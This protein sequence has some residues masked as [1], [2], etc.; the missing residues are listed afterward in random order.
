MEML[1]REP[2]ERTVRQWLAFA[3]ALVSALSA[4]VAA[5]DP[6]EER[7]LT[8]RTSRVAIVPFTNI[9]GVA[10]DGWIGVGI[11]ETLGAELQPEA[12]EVIA[13]EFL[14]S[15]MRD[16]D[17]ADNVSPDD[18]G[19]LAL[20]RRVG[21]QWVVSGGYQRVADQIRI[22]ARLVEVR[23]GVVWCGRRESMARS[24][25]SSSCRTRSPTRS[26]GAQATVRAIKLTRGIRLDAQL[27]EEVYHSVPPITDLLQ[28]VP[29]EGSIATEKTEAWIMFDQNNLYFAARVWDSAPPS[30]WVANE[31]LA[32]PG[33]SFR[34]TRSA[35]RSIRSTIGATGS[36]SIPTPSAA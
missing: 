14:G 31:M 4:P 9:T 12:F 33:R 19:V 11:A 7:P 28:Q 8:E 6:L 25:T 32:T 29:D 24:W 22:T 30:E 26:S 5:Q 36:S 18:V 17:L 34:T 2:V 27:D 10:T 1:S 13:H 20:G 23:T 16:R 15:A 3:A 35:C 21:A